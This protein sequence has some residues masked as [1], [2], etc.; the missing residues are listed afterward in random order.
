M[1]ENHA[2]TL[3]NPSEPFTRTLHQNPS[4]SHSQMLKGDLQ[5]PHHSQMLKGDLQRPQ[6]RIPL[7]D[8]QRRSAE[9]SESHSQML[10]GQRSK[11]LRSA[12]PS[13]PHSQMLKGQRSK[14][15]AQICR[16]LRTPLSDAQ[17]SSD[18]QSPHQILSEPSEPFTRTLQNPS[19]PFRKGLRKRLQV[20][21]RTL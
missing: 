4:E 21:F 16:A 7:S 12:E 9:P 17:G 11:E 8:A 3:Q 5:R 19:E 2:R 18:L 1:F 14:E 15:L 6:V 20:P 10:K 13:E